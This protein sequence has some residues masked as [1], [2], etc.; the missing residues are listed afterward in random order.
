M[1]RYRDS[2]P[3]LE[4]RFFLTDGGMETTLVFHEGEEL[5]CFAAFYLMRT[6]EGRQV[7]KDYYRRY[8]QMAIDYSAG[9]VLESVTWR[10]NPDWLMELGYVPQDLKTVNQEAIE[11]LEEIRE[12]FEQA[13]MP[14]VISGCVGPR[15]DGYVVDQAMSPQ[16]AADYHLTQIET[17]AGTNADLVTGI[18]IT[19]AEEA[20]GIVLAAKRYGMPVAI[21]FTVKTD[22][23]LPS[24]QPLGLAIEQVDGET[25]SYASYFMINCAHPTHFVDVLQEGSGWLERIRGVRANASCRSHAELDE[26][27][28]LDM[29]DPEALGREHILLKEKLPNLTVFGGCCGTDHRHVEQIA[30]NCRGMFVGGGVAEAPSEALINA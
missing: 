7:I 22:G 23:A 17:L 15:G 14:F 6:A 26:C 11:L 3:Q 5:P 9:F 29:G 24:G 19:N 28:E 10:A 8:A 2:L 12:E 20:S 16:E 4:N 13:E 25:D 1:P 27:T 21:S 18:T 30:R